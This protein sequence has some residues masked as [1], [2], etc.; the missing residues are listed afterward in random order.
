MKN[1]TFNQ[2][3]KTFTSNF[4]KKKVKAVSDLNL[5]INSG[6]IFGIIGPNGAGKSTVLKMLMGFI[7]PGSGKISVFGSSPDNPQIRFKIGYLPENPY[8]YDH[9]SAEELIRFSAVTSGMDKKN[10]DSNIDRLLKLMAL[11]NAKKR[12]LRSY[13]KGMTQRAGICFALVHDPELV[14]LDEPMS[15]LDP[16]GR[17]LVVDLIL[18][19]KTQ[20]KTVLFSS[21]ILNDIERL[22]D[23]MAIMANGKLKTILTRQDILNQQGMVTITLPKLP[24]SLSKELA[25]QVSKIEKKDDFCEIVCS[26]EK[27]PEILYKISNHGIKI[28]SLD[29]TSNTLENI[30]LKTI[31]NNKAAA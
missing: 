27:L 29:T 7:R 1:I 2:I 9:L 18:E 10:I 23:R 25:G 24:Q 13:S 14:I 8:F 11:E 3:S 22:C 31:N 4:P 16:F 20:N 6:E 5:T 28:T 12:K 17:K 19:L 21:H 15:G 30:F 26:K